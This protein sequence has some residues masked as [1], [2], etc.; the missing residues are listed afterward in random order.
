MNEAERLSLQFLETLQSSGEYLRDYI[1][2]LAQMAASEIETDAEAATQALFT[3]LIERLADSFDPRAV[4]TYNRLMAQL[5]QHC[6]KAGKGH[7]LDR[8]LNRF[9]LFTEEDLIVRAEKLA[10]PQRLNLSEAARNRIKLVIVLSRITI[11][12]DVAVTSVVI[13]RFKREFP[14]AKIALV[15]GGKASELFGGD[16]RISF[17][18][19]GYP[20]A[21]TALDRLLIW[22]DTLECVSELTKNMDSDEFMIIDPDSRL[23]QLG[24][25]PIVNHEKDKAS[26]YLFFL[27]RSYGGDTRKSLAE[28]TSL[29]LDEVFGNSIALL[30]QVSLSPRDSRLAAEVTNRMRR[31]GAERL[32]AINFGI[33][34]NPA[35]R[36]GDSF[37]QLVVTGIIQQGATVILDKGFGEEEARRA[38]EVT[39][40]AKNLNRDGRSIRVVE[41]DEEELKRLA[42]SSD[43]SKIDMLVWRGRIGLFAALIAESSLYVGYDSAFQHIA[44]AMGVRCIDIFAGFSSPRMPYRWRPTGPRHSQVVAVDTLS[45]KPNLEAILAEVLQLASRL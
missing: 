12:A 14:D 10:H 37:E 3:L 29:W 43:R 16:A 41:A 25:L 17:H 24:L 7:A 40:Q 31:D 27:S 28:L 9:D 45:Y 38:D 5:I 33:G 19:V 1:N 34:E 23:T 32:V 4:L 18:N 6:R 21:G 39:K 26:N 36:L 8:E 2:R 42:D 30:P 22:I 44:A 13:E 11:G 35:K 15:G 20:R